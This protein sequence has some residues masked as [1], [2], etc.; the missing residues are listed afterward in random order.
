VIVLSLTLAGAADDPFPPAEPVPL[1]INALATTFSVSRKH[2]L[3]LL[4]D[5]ESE[6][7]LARGGASND[8]VTILPRAPRGARKTVRLP[9]SVSD[10]VRRTGLAALRRGRSAASG[11]V[12]LTRS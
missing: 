11:S 9:V 2:V 12:A 6:G 10:P 4:R 7:L 5:A 3:T 1:S 8:Q